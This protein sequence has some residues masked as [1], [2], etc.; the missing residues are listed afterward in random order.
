MKNDIGLYIHIPFCVQKCNYCAFSS[1]AGTSDEVK[2]KY[3]DK[4]VEEITFRT[5]DLGGKKVKWIYIGGGTPNTLS[6]KQLKRIVNVLPKDCEEL[7]IELNPGLRQGFGR[8]A[9]IDNI[10][11]QVLV[12]SLLNHLAPLQ[13]LGFNRLSIGVQSFNDD[14]LKLLGRIHNSEGAKDF[15][16]NVKTAGFDN[17]NIDLMM[18]LPNQSVETVLINIETA[19]SFNPTHISAYLL[20]IDKGTQFE[21]LYK[22]GLLNLPSDEE[23]ESIYFAA[24]DK[25]ESLGYKQYEV[26]NFA[27][28]ATMDGSNFAK[29]ATMDES[30]FA[31]L[32]FECKYNLNTWRNGEYIGC[33]L[34][35]G[36]FI[37]GERFDNTSDLEQY[38]N[39]KVGAQDFVP[40]QKIENL[41][42]KILLGLRLRE[43][44]DVS[45]ELATLPNGY[46]SQFNKRLERLVKEGLLKRFEN[47]IKI[48]REKIL[49]LDKIIEDL[50][51]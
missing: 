46:K 29:K 31:K 10:G 50:L 26:S 28:M 8:Q 32:G 51:V 19:A 48:P 2:E 49:L 17:F 4:L 44:I 12:V 39:N 41:E 38:F 43:G 23:M 34:S 35:A 36:S 9:G 37:D 24:V 6:I 47:S 27:K 45:K 5:K 16:K 1:F 15:L 42:T 18:G 13:E 3:V 25:L 20:S 21:N 33:G 11:A 30:N 7:S 40:L 22:K 14:D